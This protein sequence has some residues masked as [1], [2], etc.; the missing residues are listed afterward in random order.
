[1]SDTPEIAIEPPAP[2]RSR[3]RI[4]AG[5]VAV[6]AIIGGV[7]FAAAS[8]GDSGSN[9]PE[10]P[11]RAMFA[12]AQQGDVLGVMAELDPGERDALRGP[13]SDLVTELNRL[14]VRKDAH[15]DHL[16]GVQLQVEGLELSSDAVDSGLAHVRINKGSSS[17]AVDPDKLPLGGSPAT[18]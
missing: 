4:V 9:S 15:L 7:A 18:A 14:D 11:V 5:F 16:T 3:G 12:A 17:Y 6:V 13:L 2:R 1:M 8:L 10:D